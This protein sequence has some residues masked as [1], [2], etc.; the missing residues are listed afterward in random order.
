MRSVYLAIACC[1]L[2]AAQ[3]T[4]TYLYDGLGDRVRGPVTE[5]RGDSRTE[6]V[7][8]LNGRSV[9]VEQ[10]EERVLSTDGSTKTVERIIRRYDPA[11]APAGTERIVDR[12]TQRPDGS[13]SVES[14][15]YRRDISGNLTLAERASTQVRRSGATESASTV[16]ERPGIDG[17]FQVAERREV[18]KEQSATRDTR[19]AVLLRR[20]EN[21][22]FMEAEKENVETSKNG[23][24]TVS[25]AARYQLG[26]SGRLELATQTVTTAVKRQDGSQSIIEDVYARQSTGLANDNAT[27]RLKEQRVIERAVTAGGIT[28]T[29]ALRQPSP[30]DPGRLGPP[31]K[32]AETVCKGKCE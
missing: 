5:V 7:E 26:S 10:V 22:R 24:Q 20:D 11:G 8:S 31:R 21:G 1:T 3:T 2:L 4:R 30:G 32:V 17:S 23:E 15:L 12:I 27:P 19:N 25:N 18:V 6:V 28:E 13:T 16:V 9:P 14:S 29:V